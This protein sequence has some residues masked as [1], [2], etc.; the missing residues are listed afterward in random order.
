M[1]MHVRFLLTGLVGLLFSVGAAA[2]P[3]SYQGYAEDGGSPADGTYDLQFSVYNALNGGAQQ[4]STITVDDAS[5]TDGI[6]SAELDFPP[7]LFGGGA[8]RWLEVRIRPGAG[9]TYTTL[10]PRTRLGAS[11]VALSMPLVSVNKSSGVVSTTGRVGVNVTSPAAWLEAHT[12]NNRNAIYGFQTSS[13]SGYSGYFGNAAGTS[14]NG[15]VVRVFNNGTGPTVLAD[16]FNAS[17]DDAGIGAVH[18]GVGPAVYGRALGSGDAAYFQGGNLS[19]LDDA[20]NPE[21]TFEDDAVN[22]AGQMRMYAPN[23]TTTVLQMVASENGNDG[24]EIDLYD[25]SGTNTFTL[26]AENFDEGGA[27]MQLR[28]GNG[29]STVTI[30]GDYLSTGQGRIVTDELQLNGSD[31]AEN[32]DVRALA[33]AAPVAGTVVCIDA[34]EAGRLVVC[35]SAYDRTVAGVISGAGGVR[36][37]IYMSQPGTL[38][39]GEHPVAIS[40]RVYV[41]ADASHGAIQPGDLMTTTDTPGHAMVATDGARAQG[42]ILGKAMSSLDEGTGLVL[43]LVS[44]Q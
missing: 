42:A 33:G 15:Q 28:D 24:A 36:P 30:Y 10:S 35:N 26:D 39:D 1:N 11:P 18:R 20:G 8:D 12:G 17:N 44:L 34:E 2:Q 27:W 3:I 16:V 25:D 38:A 19:F 7:E 4:G 31:L 13:G 41:M 32:F 22:G 40:G 37:G 21:I 9:G 43:V 23:G 6:F 5:I 14:Y 29:L